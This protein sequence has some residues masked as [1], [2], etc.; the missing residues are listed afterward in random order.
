[1]SAEKSRPR[2]AVV[3]PFLDQSYGTERHVVEWLAVLADSF[4]IHIYSQHVQDVDLRKVKWHR[5]PKLRGPHLLNYIWWLAANH[6]RR[7]FDRWFGGLRYDLTFSPGINCL[8][9]DVVSVHIV[10]GEYA[11]KNRE[12]N[13]FSR[14]PVRDWPRLFHRK[15]YYSLIAF[16]ERRVYTRGDITLILVAQKTLAPLSQYYSRNDASPVVYPGIDSRRF[17]SQRRSGMRAEARRQIGIEDDSFALVLIGNDWRNKGVPVLLEALALLNDPLIELFIVSREDAAPAQALAKKLGL[18]ERVHF[19]PPRTDVEFYY[20]AADV[21][22]APSLED[23]FALPPAEAMACGLPVI[24]SSTAGVSEMVTDGVDGLVLGNPADARGLASMIDRLHKDREFRSRLGE[25]A[26][27]TARQYTWER[28]GRQLGAILE[29][30]VHAREQGMEHK[31]AQG[32][33][34]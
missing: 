25:N 11:K 8:D 13:R 4:D 18:A 24:V 22:V 21:C 30:I 3:T 34:S 2:L 31:L 27:R 15:L 32:P 29:G 28:S 16:L 33:N 14:H 19:L 17:D 26:A 6:L 12:V 20:A 1:M 9:A 7:A 23:T 5:I 10:F